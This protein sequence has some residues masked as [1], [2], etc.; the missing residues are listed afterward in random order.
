MHERNG[1]VSFKEHP[2]YN[3]EINR[4]N[5]SMEYIENAILATEENKRIH[6]EE[7]KD[8]FV[9]LDYLDSSQSYVSI[10]VNAKLLDELEKNYDNLIRYRKKP[11]F[12][13]IDFRQENHDKKDK[14]YIGK[15]TLYKPEWEVPMIIDWRSPV[16]SIYYDGRLGDVS[17]ETQTGLV[18]GELYLK[19]QYTIDDGKLESFM[20][21]DITATDTFLQASLGANADNRLKDIVSTIQSEQNA[22]IRADIEKPLVVQGVAGSGKTTI[23]LHRIAYLIYT[24]SETFYP[25]NFMIIAPNQLFLNYI[26]DVL[27]EL[28]VD[29]VKQTTFID[30]VLELIGKKYKLTD[31]SE[32]LT[33]IVDGTSDVNE[34]IKKISAFKGSLLFKNI[35]EVFIKK[36][37]LD[38]VP[39]E[40]FALGDCIIIS[41][42]EIKKSFIK[43]YQN[44]PL[45][46]RVNEIKKSLTNRLKMNKKN[47]LEDI[48][49]QYDR[50]IDSI[51][52]NEDESEERRIKIVSLIEERD[53]A[54][55]DVKK[56][57]NTLI[58]KYIAKFPSKDLFAYYQEIIADEKTL[59]A[60]S[61]GK[62]SDE[63]IKSVCEYSVGI[64]MTK[65]IE[66]ED[67]AAL[68]YLK[69][70][71]FGFE[72]KIDIKYVVIDEAQ[73]FSHFQFYA[74]KKIFN[75][76]LFTI[77]GDLSQGIH[78]Y[79]A[80]KNWDFVL[81][82]IFDS[83]KSQYLTLEQSYRTTVEIMNLANRVIEMC[84]IEG[85]ILAK[86]VVRHGDQPL[87]LKMNFTEEIMKAT[88]SQ[89]KV[90]KQS[91]YHSIAIIG[92]TL[93]ECKN[94]Y[95]LLSKR[96]DIKVKLLDEKE[97]IYNSDVVIVP[98]YLAKG[99]EFDAVIIINIDDV[100]TNDELDLKLLYVAM[101]RALHRMHIYYRAA[102]M[103]VLD[104]IM[105][106]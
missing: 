22:I 85:L 4:L 39:D 24:Y 40:D 8:A 59:K 19:R 11:Y 71:V 43:D 63:F 25:D 38:F 16:A 1:L 67:L 72:Q 74:L 62:I 65:H 61:L 56:S 68:A 93:K 58:S 73:D 42:K 79:R 106:E 89:I 13:R 82:K 95:K 32:K 75:T 88:E 14:L 103:P 98:S 48:E 28:G 99:L 29:K 69:H 37:E 21:I 34:S 70:R 10:L 90:L 50:R 64:L 105:S 47:V 3:E 31:P 6:R 46:Q 49:K 7:I 55:N 78:S 33:S 57:A 80:I 87:V 9:N 51:R 18:N 60:C 91:G 12:A 83:S 35:I 100:Y 41:A 92:K 15:M 17:Y 52:H 77:L 84:P 30:Y 66:F 23:A 102:T 54:L 36:L 94:I 81:N 20:D 45:Y 86:P 104:S 5:E 26:S 101:T 53:Q 96:K 27:P 2:D 76:E 97:S 44:L